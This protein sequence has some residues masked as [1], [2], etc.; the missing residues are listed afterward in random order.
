MAISARIVWQNMA[1]RSYNNVH[2]K[3][4]DAGQVEVGQKA[5]NTGW[6]YKK[7]M[8]WIGD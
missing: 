6:A 3:K 5:S 8:F 1:S 7:V 4:I 2:D